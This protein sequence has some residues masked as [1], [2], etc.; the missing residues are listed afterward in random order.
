MPTNPVLKRE[1]DNLIRYVGPYAKSANLPLDVDNYAGAV[2]TLQ[3][4][5]E[6]YEMRVAEAWVRTR[7][8]VEAGVSEVTCPN[9]SRPFFESGDDIYWVSPTGFE[10]RRTATTYTPGTAVTTP[11]TNFDTLSWT[12]G[13]LTEDMP[14]GT[15]IYLLRKGTNNDNFPVTFKAKPFK[16]YTDL[17]LT[18][19]IETELPGTPIVSSPSS[20]FPA[21]SIITTED[22]KVAEDQEVFNI[23]DIGTGAAQSVDVGRRIRVKIGGDIAMAEYGATHVA[24]ADDWGWE[25]TVPDLLGSSAEIKAGDVVRLVVTLSGVAGLAD[26]QSVLAHV[27]ER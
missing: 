3:L 27:V 7:E 10:N 8:D 15:R 20:L 19:E 17:G 1:A 2:V 6:D 25:A 16:L 13:V 23:L 9:F 18:L 12:D 5:A 11:A 22:G 24:G 14:K 21:Q 26:V 4:F